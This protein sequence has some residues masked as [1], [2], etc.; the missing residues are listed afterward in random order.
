MQERCDAVIVAAGSG[1]RLGFAQPKAFVPLAGRPLL[2][3]SLET[4]LAHPAIGRI[5]LAVPAALVDQTSSA[6]GSG[7]V[8]VVA[9]GAQRW[10]S[11]RNGCAASTAP[12]VLVHDAARP[13]VSAAIIDALLGLRARFDCAFTATPVV[14][15]IRT[16]TED[17]AGE[18]IDRSKLVRVGTP[19]LFSASLLPAC[20]DLAATLPSP[21]TDE[22]FLM[23]QTGVTAGIA[24]GDPKNFKIT[25]KEDLEMAEA[26]LLA[27]RRRDGAHRPPHR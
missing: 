14:D 9:G 1:T 27:G 10:E 7:R 4:F 17:V 24:P 19:Q 3:H 16:I 21:P 5:I 8:T 15:T 23:Q 25:T 13:F 20:F 6:F 11:V 12:W 2:A 18:T 22:V 26:L